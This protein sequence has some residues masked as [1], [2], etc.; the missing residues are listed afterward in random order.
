[1]KI[2]G[3]KRD[4]SNEVLLETIE[5]LEQA[6][7][8]NHYLCIGLKEIIIQRL[9]K[10]IRKKTGIYEFNFE[11]NMI[12]FS[13]IPFI[14]CLKSLFIDF[15]KSYWILQP[16]DKDVRTCCQ[17]PSHGRL[18]RD[19]LAQQTAESEG[20]GTA[21]QQISSVGMKRPTLVWI[22]LIWWGCLLDYKET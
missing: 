16:Q 6:L 11:I 12:W 1:M 13:F 9:M 10:N 18:G 22:W 8:Q 20:W 5:M 17:S 2:I 15:R 4:E 7:H 19:W 21:V 3:S 14:N